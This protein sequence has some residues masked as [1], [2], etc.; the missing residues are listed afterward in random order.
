MT[1]VKIWRNP[2]LELRWVKFSNW[3][4][5]KFAFESDA[6]DDIYEKYTDREGD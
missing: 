5:H 6:F 3:M 4:N 1:E 2:D